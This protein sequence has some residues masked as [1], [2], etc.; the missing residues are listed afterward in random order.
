MNKNKR[1]RIEG[2]KERLEEIAAELEQL[3]AEEQ[4]AFNNMPESLQGSERGEQM[5]S[6]ISELEDAQS[7]AGSLA[8][9]LG[10]LLNQ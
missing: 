1:T 2:L 4:E 6:N 9:K 3:A 5:E 10:E 7:D 8:E